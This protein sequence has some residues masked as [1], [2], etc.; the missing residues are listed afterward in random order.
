M[1]GWQEQPDSAGW[2]EVDAP[3]WADLPA[4]WVSE[5]GIPDGF[6]LWLPQSVYYGET[7]RTG[8]KLVDT[9]DPNLMT[10]WWKKIVVPDLCPNFDA[11]D[12]PA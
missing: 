10:W 6:M 7:G 4:F 1:Q 9:D 8:E 11:K 5:N 3:G 2:W 12:D